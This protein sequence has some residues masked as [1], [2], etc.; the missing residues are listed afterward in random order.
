M[1]T[2]VKQYYLHLQPWHFIL[3]LATFFGI[4]VLIS[5]ERLKQIPEAVTNASFFVF[6]GEFAETGYSLLFFYNEKSE[7]C[8]KMRYSIEQFARENKEDIHFFEV[9][10]NA[11]PEYYLEFNLSGVPNILIFEN[12]RELTRIMGVVPVMFGRNFSSQ[13]LINSLFQSYPLPV[14]K[15]F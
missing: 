14:H 9:N 3:S 8:A 1:E 15:L 2:K 4:T 7:E 11:H 6:D 5:G 12:N 10:I 13:N